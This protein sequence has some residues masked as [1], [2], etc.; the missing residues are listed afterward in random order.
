MKDIKTLVRRYIEDSI[1]MGGSTAFADG[2]SLIEHRIVDSTG[3]LELI[4]FIEDEC[5]FTVEDDEMVPDNLGSLDRIE[6]YVRHK[7]QA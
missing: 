2:D 1:L 6:A 7:L 5:G 4:A 3:F